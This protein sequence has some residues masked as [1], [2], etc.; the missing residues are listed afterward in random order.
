MNEK[1]TIFDYARMCNAH[2]DCGICPIQGMS[3]CVRYSRG[4]GDIDKANEIILNWCKTHPAKTR[5]S[6]FLKMFP[7]A[8][9]SYDFID[10]CPRTI[11]KR[12]SGKKKCVGESCMGCKREY[13]LAEVE[14]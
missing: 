10:I 1:A 13:W 12:L 9:L 14:R 2:S 11:D 4:V 6:E 5:Q 7:N 3:L 8:D